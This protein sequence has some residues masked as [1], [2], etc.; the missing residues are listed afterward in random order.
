M[1]H[2]AGL[3]LHLKHRLKTIAAMVILTDNGFDL[4]TFI[5]IGEIK[6]PKLITQGDWLTLFK[7][8]RFLLLYLWCTSKQKQYD[9]D[10][11]NFIH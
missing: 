1:R 8:D 10:S 9:S 4:F 5:K 11:Y 2:F 3:L 6:R 7:N